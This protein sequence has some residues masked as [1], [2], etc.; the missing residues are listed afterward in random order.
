MKLKTFIVAGIFASILAVGFP[1]VIAQEV[2]TQTED[3]AP[4]EVTPISE[5]TSTDTEEDR[6]KREKMRERLQQRKE[7]QQVRI[8]F[9]RRNRIIGNCKS[10]Q[11][12]IKSL[13]GRINGIETS[14]TQIY[15]KLQNLLRSVSE[16]TVAAGG[17]AT[18]LNQQLEQ[19]DGLIE[20]LYSEL[21]V[22]KQ[23]V[24]DLAEMECTDDPEAFEAT[25]QS[26]RLS[27]GTT[28]QAAVNTRTHIN[29]QIKP[30][31]K[32]IRQSLS[33]SEDQ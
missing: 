20:T 8:S 22:Y 9:A 29:D 6:S 2:R 4:L 14:R 5:E 27:A 18:A 15:E 24:T 1:V 33:E 23:A 28:K 16:K 32:A 25:L 3:S 17:D 31:L 19:L 21:E 13:E 30:A 7:N 26:A 11:G 12:K 10:A